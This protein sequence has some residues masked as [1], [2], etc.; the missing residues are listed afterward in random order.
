[1]RIVQNNSENKKQ[2]GSQNS[3]SQDCRDRVNTGTE[4]KKTGTENKKNNNKQF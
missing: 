4:N 2:Q 3:K 1:M